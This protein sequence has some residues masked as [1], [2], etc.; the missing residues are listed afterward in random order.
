MNAFDLFW[1]ANDENSTM[2]IP[3]KRCTYLL[4]LMGGSRVEDWVH[5]QAMT[6]SKRVKRT[7]NPI[8]K[9]DE[10]LW[11]SLKTA[12]ERSFAY[13]NKVKDAK[14]QLAR[15]EM[16][17]DNID[18]YIAKFEN[19]VRKAGIP[20]QEQGILDRFKDGLKRGIHTTIL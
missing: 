2:T 17:A 6:L 10:Q 12:F 13:T 3:Y 19:L 18:D 7:M 11:E 15:L 4:S 1:M 8:T 20:R 9:D 14:H 16:Q 5:D